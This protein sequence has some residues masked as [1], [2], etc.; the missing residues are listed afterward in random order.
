MPGTFAYRYSGGGRAALAIWRIN[1]AVTPVVTIDCR[2][3]DARVRQWD[4]K[5]LAVVQ[6]EGTVTIRL[7]YLGVPLYVEW[8]EDQSTGGRFFPETGHRVAEPFLRYWNDHGGLAQFGLPIT[9]PVN[10]PAFGTGKPRLVQYFE[11]NRFEYHPEGSDPAF[12]VQLGRLGDELLARNQIDWRTFPRASDA[13]PA[14]LVFGE[15]GHRICPPFRAYWE[16]NGGL[17]LYGMPLTEAYEENGLTVQYF[18]RNRF[19]YHPAKAGTPYEIQL[20]L[21]GREIYSRWGV[22]P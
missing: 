17:S 6:T 19:E 20:G 1:A 10:E 9:G 8:G 11:R 12:R 15:T 2:C 13:N 21:L 5:V 16:R 3:R 14:C 7:D 22:W 18:E 4:G